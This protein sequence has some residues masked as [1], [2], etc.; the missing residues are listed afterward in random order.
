MKKII[1]DTFGFLEWIQEIQIL[2]YNKP[3]I[4]LPVVVVVTLVVVVVLLVVVVFVV[5][6]VLV[7]VVVFVVVEVVGALVVAGEVA[8]PTNRKQYSCLH[9]V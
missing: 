5:V 6:V 3:S 9:F 2:V 8:A 4:T 7:V 1:T